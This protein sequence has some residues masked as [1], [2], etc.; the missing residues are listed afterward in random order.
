[1]AL[2]LAGLTGVSLALGWL[3]P[4]GT[5]GE[6]SVARSKSPPATLRSATC[7]LE[8][9]RIGIAQIDVTLREHATLAWTA[10]AAAAL[11]LWLYGR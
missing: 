11:A 6:R 3:G 10:L 5:G 2:G 1:M 9:A 4:E 7:A 8:R